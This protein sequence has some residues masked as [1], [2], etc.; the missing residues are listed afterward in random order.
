LLPLRRI[1]SELHQLTREEP[2]LLYGMY[3]DFLPALLGAIAE[4]A[5]K[6]LETDLVSLEMRCY[7]PRD[8][9]PGLLYCRRRWTTTL[10][11]QR[12]LSSLQTTPLADRW[13]DA[14]S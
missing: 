12:G 1:E 6:R 3:V 10:N 13:L 8:C 5:L 9:S 14:L 2:E 11:R 4:P 7:T